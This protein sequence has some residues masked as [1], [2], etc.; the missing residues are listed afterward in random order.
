MGGVSDPFQPI[1]RSAKISY[2]CLKVLAE[3]KYPFIVSTKSTLVAEKEYLDLLSQCN[4]CLQFSMACSSYNKIE[5]GAPTFEER[6]KAV[7]KVSSKV[8]R[9]I[10]RIQPYMHEY[11]DEILD[12]L[13]KLKEAGA[14]G[15]IIESIKYRKAKKNNL[16][17]VGGD[18][19]YPYDLIYG[20]F[21]KLKK[22]A[23]R[24]GLKIYAGE[25]RLRKYGDS[26]TCCGIDG[27][28][29]FI[30]NKFNLNHLLNGD[31]QYPTD[32][33]KENKTGTCFKG[34]SQTTVK[35]NEKAM[36][37]FAFNMLD[38]YKNSKKSIN[39]IMGVTRK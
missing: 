20:D 24:V 32:K 23:H 1:E 19:V 16:V 21:M 36:N 15:I 37:S 35:G 39:E 17:K 14:Y 25:N 31:K 26:L 8:P 10:I 13:K 29:G 3:T 11:L 27:L 33:M 5:T 34:M 6:L 22:E 12:N 38:L 4:V 7:K 9:V 28:E 30:P 18:M 2:E